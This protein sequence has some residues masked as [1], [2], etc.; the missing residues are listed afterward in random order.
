MCSSQATAPVSQLATQFRLEADNEA[1]ALLYVLCF[2]EC[3]RTCAYRVCV[4]SRVSGPQPAPLWAQTPDEAAS[5][6]GPEHPRPRQVWRVCETCGDRFRTL[7]EKNKHVRGC[8]G[9]EA[10]AKLTRAR[11]CADLILT[12]WKDAAPTQ[13]PP[14]RNVDVDDTGYYKEFAQWLQS[15]LGYCTTGPTRC[16]RSARTAS[17]LRED[18]AFLLRH[19]PLDTSL[20]LAVL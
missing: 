13:E 8:G 17:V 11:E 9:L 20:D 14:S 6:A 7:L 16:V 18:I 19:A 3:V 15:P 1:K 10:A 12:L 5:T 2:L 4:S